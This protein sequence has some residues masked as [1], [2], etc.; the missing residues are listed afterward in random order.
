[1]FAFGWLI[2]QPD[3]T[4]LTSDQDVKILILGRLVDKTPALD[5]FFWQS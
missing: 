5:H 2:S 3:L 4:T 1:M